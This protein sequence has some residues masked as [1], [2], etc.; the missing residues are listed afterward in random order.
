MS[1]TPS[2]M[3]Y[4]KFVPGFYETPEAQFEVVA[5]QLKDDDKAVIVGAAFGRDVCCLMEKMRKYDAKFKLYA[6]DP[7]GEEIE[8][9]H[10]ESNSGDTPWGE[11]IPAWYSRMRGAGCFFDAFRFYTSNSPARKYLYDYVQNTS[12]C[13]NE[14]EPESVAFIYLSFSKTSKYLRK[15]LLSW[16][17]VVKRG[18]VLIIQDFGLKSVVKDVFQNDLIVPLGLTTSMIMKTA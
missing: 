5:S 11:P 18:G 3:E 6:I 14:F 13:G 4:W 10:G 2:K 17:P 9:I 1:L 12:S 15:D 8:A 16:W 7:W